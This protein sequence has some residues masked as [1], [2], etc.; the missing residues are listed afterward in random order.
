MMT[1][2]F[3]FCPSTDIT[4]SMFTVQRPAL[5]DLHKLS[6]LD[7]SIPGFCHLKTNNCVHLH[8]QDLLWHPVCPQ[9]RACPRSP[10]RDLQ[11]CGSMENTTAVFQNWFQ[12]VQADPTWG[13]QTQ[14]RTWSPTSFPSGLY[15]YDWKPSMFSLKDKSPEAVGSMSRSYANF[16]YISGIC[17]KCSCLWCSSLQQLYRQRCDR[18]TCCTCLMWSVLTRC[19]PLVVKRRHSFYGAPDEV[20]HCYF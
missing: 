7:M 11:R 2:D 16:N 18:Q 8:I 19:C 12:R 1:V 10:R 14:T 6:F 20:I 4:I 17:Q 9:A 15:Q 13:I 5:V 3:P